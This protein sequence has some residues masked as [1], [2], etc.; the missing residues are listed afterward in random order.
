M[1]AAVQKQDDKFRLAD[2][3]HA[4]PGVGRDWIRTLLFKLKK[5][6][7]IDCSGKGKGARWKRVEE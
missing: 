2:I 6:G 3:E 4:C 7:K 5:E 1:L